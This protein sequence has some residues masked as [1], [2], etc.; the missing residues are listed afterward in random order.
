MISGTTRGHFADYAAKRISFDE[1]SRKTRS[2]WAAAARYLMTRWKGP[3]AVE[4]DDLVQELLLEAWRSFPMHDPLRGDLTEFICYQA[5]SRAKRWLHGQ[6]GRRKCSRSDKAPSRFPLR[7]SSIRST[8][9]DEDL[10]TFISEVLGHV[11]ADQEQHVERLEITE[12]NV[13]MVREAL[14]RPGYTLNDLK[15]MQ[16]YVA[17]DG[18]MT[19]AL[20]ILSAEYVPLVDEAHLGTLREMLELWLLRAVSHAIEVKRNELLIVEQVMEKEY[21][22]RD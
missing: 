5:T 3:E 7:F 4:V 16:S 22:N 1:F 20:E 18:N 6:R 17:A 13:R 2:F 10:S 19:R 21:D 12:E 15:V 11:E 14:Q 9:N 8:G